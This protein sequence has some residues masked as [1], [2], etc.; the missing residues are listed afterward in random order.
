MAA[1]L[2]VLCLLLF[3]TQ[4]SPTLSL[5]PRKGMNS[6]ESFI[7]DIRDQHSF[8]IYLYKLLLDGIH[9]AHEFNGNDHTFVCDILARYC[10]IKNA[11]FGQL[12][13]QTW[14]FSV[15]SVHRYLG[16]YGC[17][18]LLVIKDNR[19]THDVQVIL[20]YIFYYVEYALDEAECKD[21]VY[22]N[23]KFDLLQIYILGSKIG[24]NYLQLYL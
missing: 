8:P 23:Y 2:H 20:V 22:I 3:I 4:T 11:D 1:M 6:R 24:H 21:N 9:L 5:L 10:C 7:E 13:I 17:H 12:I 19:G 16:I 18:Y 14:I 15:Y